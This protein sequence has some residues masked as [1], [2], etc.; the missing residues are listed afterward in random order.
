MAAS[1]EKVVTIKGLCEP[2]QLNGGDY[3][4][5][6][7]VFEHFDAPRKNSLKRYDLVTR[8]Y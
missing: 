7:A 5:S 4:I 3:V 2:L 1:E 6:V 8:S